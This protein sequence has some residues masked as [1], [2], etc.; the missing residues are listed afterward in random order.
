LK[1]KNKDSLKY[2]ISEEIEKIIFYDDLNK[3]IK[4]RNL[5]TFI[6]WASKTFEK[7]GEYLEDIG[8]P[9]TRSL[10]SSFAKKSNKLAFNFLFYSYAEYLINIPSLKIDPRLLEDAMKHEGYIIELFKEDIEKA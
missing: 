8:D 10:I 2:L 1:K 9:L 7:F 5:L 4:E 6:E 3:L